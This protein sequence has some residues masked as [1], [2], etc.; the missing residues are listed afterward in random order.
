MAIHPGYMG[1]CEIDDVTK[2]R[3]ESASITAKQAFETPDMVMGH[4]DRGA[5]HP[6]KIDISGSIS[7]PATEGFVGTSGGADS[8]FKWVVHRGDCGQLD[9]KGLKLIYYCDG[10]SGIGGGGG[11]QARKFTSVYANNV[12]FS[13]SAGDN[14]QFSVDVMSMDM[15][16]WTDLTPTKNEDTEKVITWDNTDVTITSGTGVIVPTD[17]LLSSF[18][19]SINNNCAPYYSLTAD[20]GYLPTAIIPGLRSVTG[21]LTAYDPQ[22]FD[23]VYGFDSVE[24]SSGTTWDAGDARATLEFSIGDQTFKFKVMFHRNEPTLTV[25]PIMS[26]I[27]FTGTGI[28]TDLN[29]L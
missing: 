10:S 22:A 15:P 29:S 18:E 27:A 13:C 7:G 2:F 8:L 12:N 19:F 21:S 28:Q 1:T 20:R 3:F 23:A 5:Y 4:W 6:G 26:T 9:S 17:A 25:G 24:S 16:E 14:A 11:K